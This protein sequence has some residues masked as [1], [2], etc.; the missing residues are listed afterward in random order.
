MAVPLKMVIVGLDNK[1]WGKVAGE[2]VADGAHGKSGFDVGDVVSLPVAVNP[3][4]VKVE[5]CQG[6]KDDLNEDEN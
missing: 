5:G 6:E 1:G 3:F 2:G 4:C